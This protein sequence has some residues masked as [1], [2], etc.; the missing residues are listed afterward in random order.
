M[1]GEEAG[2]AGGDGAGD[3]AEFCVV[4]QVRRVGAGEGEVGDEERHGEADAAKQGDRGEHLPVRL[5]GHGGE[6]E[7]YGQP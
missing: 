6:A 4:E 5:L 7:L 2:E 1:Q 3:D